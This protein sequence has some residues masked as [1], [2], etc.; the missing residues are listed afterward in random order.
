[1]A[2]SY[3]HQMCIRDRLQK[4]PELAR[5]IPKGKDPPEPPRLGKK[6]G[7][8][9]C[10]PPALTPVSYTHL[11]GLYGVADD[12]VLDAQALAGGLELVAGLGARADGGDNGVAGDGELLARCV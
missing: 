8:Q 4:H 7:R 9:N 10:R 2:V 3:T 5:Y 6:R 1:M 12:V 11:A